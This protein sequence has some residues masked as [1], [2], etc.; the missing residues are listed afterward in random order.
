MATTGA[1]VRRVGIEAI[2]IRLHDLVA[3][4]KEQSDLVRRHLTNERIGRVEG[5]AE[6]GHR[7]ERI[8]RLR[9]GKATP[10]LRRIAPITTDLGDHSR[11][12]EAGRLLH[13]CPDV[14][15]DWE[16]CLTNNGARARG[17]E[18][19]IGRTCNGRDQFVARTV[20]AKHDKQKRAHCT[21]VR[22]QPARL[23]PLRARRSA[24]RA[25]PRPWLLDCSW[26][27]L[28]CGP[29]AP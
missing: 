27:Q 3:V 22:P 26:P 1:R 28:S 15:A 19:S 14:S 21:E 5:G 9:A 10:F 12:R 24:S 16:G 18:A 6:P 17:P 7:G 29:P 2:R 20:P 13:C 25:W 11:G 4:E 23:H 8:D